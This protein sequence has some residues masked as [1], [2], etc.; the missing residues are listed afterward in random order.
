MLDVSTKGHDLPKFR[1]VNHPLSKDINVS[2][3]EL[4]DVLIFRILPF[5]F[6][7]QPIC[8]EA[9]TAIV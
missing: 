1:W 4:M 7:A 5:T 9:C 2:I 3:L 8:C 6:Y